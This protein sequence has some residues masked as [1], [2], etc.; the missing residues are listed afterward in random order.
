MNFISLLIS[1]RNIP[2]SCKDCKER[3]AEECGL[4]LI[5]FEIESEFLADDSQV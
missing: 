1:T 4:T 5:G 2:E 3:L